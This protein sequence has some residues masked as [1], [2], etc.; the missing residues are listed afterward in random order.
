MDKKTI[1]IGG[2]VGGLCSG[3]R[4]LSKGYTV[5]LLEKNEK[6]G[7]KINI[8]ENSQFKFDL[9]ASVVMTPKFILIYLMMWEKTIKIILNYIS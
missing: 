7:G 8:I 3:I 4:L 2:G 5:T 9:T 1:I 6:L